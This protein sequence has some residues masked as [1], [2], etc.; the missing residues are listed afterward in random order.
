MK[1]GQ[2]LLLR[3]YLGSIDAK[4]KLVIFGAGENGIR[5]LLY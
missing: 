1:V 3:A 5:L 4:T 2:K